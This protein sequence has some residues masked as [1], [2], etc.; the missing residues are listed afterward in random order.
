MKNDIIEL[1][2]SRVQELD[3]LIVKHKGTQH[4]Y[5]LMAGKFELLQLGVKLESIQD[6]QHV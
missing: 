3:E 1:I 6:S 2:K 4:E 5:P